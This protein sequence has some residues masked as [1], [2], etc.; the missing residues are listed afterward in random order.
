MREDLVRLGEPVLAFLREHEPAVGED[1]ELRSS[2]FRR[3]RLVALLLELRGEAHGPP[4]VPV[5][6]GAVEDLD[7][8]HA[9]T[10]HAR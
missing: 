8:R 2:P 3:D 6:D 1:V 4:V 7:A 9:V 10:L 5:S